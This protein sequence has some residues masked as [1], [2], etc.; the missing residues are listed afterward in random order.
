MNI[1][2]LRTELQDASYSAMT[3]QEAADSLNAKT[4]DTFVPVDSAELLAWSLVKNGGTSSRRRRIKEASTSHAS[5]DIQ[6]LCEGALVMIDKDNTEF[7]FNRPERV[8]LLDALVAGG[9]LT[10]ADKTALQNIATV[11]VSRA[12]QLKLG[13]VKVGHVQIAR[14]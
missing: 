6:D 5:P 1:Q 4:I 7:D 2:A 13:R 11:Q 12:D 3:D 9:V 14:A 10:A 8:A